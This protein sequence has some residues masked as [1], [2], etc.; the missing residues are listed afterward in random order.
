MLQRDIA[1]GHACEVIADGA[2]E[3]VGLYAS[4]G[5]TADFLGVF[6]IVGEERLQ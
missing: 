5:L 1:I 6:Q 4:A 3:A 2:V